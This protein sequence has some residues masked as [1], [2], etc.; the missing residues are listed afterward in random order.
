M[1]YKPLHS[2]VS[3]VFFVVKTPELTLY[4]SYLTFKTTT[5][6]CLIT[7]ALLSLSLSLQ[8]MTTIAHS[9]PLGGIELSAGAF[10][11]TPVGIPLHRSAVVI[12][13]L[14][15][16]ASPVVDSENNFVSLRL[17]LDRPIGAAGDY[18]PD[19]ETGLPSH[20]LEVVTGSAAG[21]RFPIVGSG[22]DWLIIE[23]EPQGNLV[24][25]FDPSEVRDRIRIRPCWTPESF[26]PA[27][28]APL[29]AEPDDSAY[30]IKMR[31]SDAIIIPGKKSDSHH[32]LQRFSKDVNSN[33]YWA[34][35]DDDNKRLIA[36]NYGILP[37]KVSWIR[38]TGAN[39]AKWIV[40]GD[41][42]NFDIR[43][44]IPLPDSGEMLKWPVTL[45]EPKAVTLNSSGLKSV[46]R[47]S[48][49][50]TERSDEL[51]VWEDLTGFYSRPAKRFYLQSA[52]PEP[53]WREV[54]DDSTDQ[55]L[56]TLEPGKAYTIRRRG[57]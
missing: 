27:S 26:M 13:D 36:D 11:E 8:A 47:V 14:A 12:A 5:K 43:W 9:P 25:S 19:P 21:E 18:D 57:E 7:S 20:Y 56:Y 40:T 17:F 39:D 24:A 48:A 51:V 42:T 53:V 28:E 34:E 33:H 45:T 52:S 22:E 10:R 30:R 23:Q 46:F 44:A 37:G 15:E 31:D 3:F 54:G 32:M 49:S 50:A 4:G 41:V 6:Q 16:V 55:G 29:S 35:W 38:R 1:F 2:F